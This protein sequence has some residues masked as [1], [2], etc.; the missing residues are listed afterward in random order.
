MRFRKGPRDIMRIKVN[1]EWTRQPDPLTV[2]ELLERL[3]LQP[4]WV[5]VERN[6]ELVRRKDFAQTPLADQDQIELVTLVGGG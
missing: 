4:K 6:R 1:G 3:D 5:A 2:A